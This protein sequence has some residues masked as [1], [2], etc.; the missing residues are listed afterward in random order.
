MVFITWTSDIVHP[1]PCIVEAKVS[2]TASF[3]RS[4]GNRIV[5]VGA[6]QISG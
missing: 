4:N 1:D 2:R 6:L 3:V 5:S